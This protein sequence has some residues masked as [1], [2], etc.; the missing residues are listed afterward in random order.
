MEHEEARRILRNV[1]MRARAHIEVGGPGDNVFAGIDEGEIEQACHHF[2][3]KCEPRGVVTSPALASL[4]ARGLND[5]TGLTPAEVQALCGCV[6]GQ[7]EKED[8]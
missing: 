5:P 4:A 3:W 1:M 6:L 7:R 2:I 8:E